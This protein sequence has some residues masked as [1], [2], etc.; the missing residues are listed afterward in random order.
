M[1]IKYQFTQ[2]DAPAYGEREQELCFLYKSNSGRGVQLQNILSA[3]K[4]F[5]KVSLVADVSTV[6]DIHTHYNINSYPHCLSLR[7]NV[8]SMW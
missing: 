4:K 2:T 1:R 5:E 8:L 6:R 3:A 7:V